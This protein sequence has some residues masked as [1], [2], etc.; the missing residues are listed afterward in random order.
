MAP[1]FKP[2][3]EDRKARFRKALIWFLALDALIVVGVVWFLFL[4]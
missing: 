1:P 2:D 4:R 3:T